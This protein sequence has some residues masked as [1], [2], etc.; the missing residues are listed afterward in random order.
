MALLLL[1][2]LA[3][4]IYWHRTS[5]SDMPSFRKKAVFVIRIIIIILIVL[6]LAGLRIK[7]PKRELSILFVVDSSLSISPEN[8][9]W[10][11]DYIRNRVK[12]LPAGDRAGVIVFGKNAYLEENLGKTPKITRFSTIINS[13]YTNISGAL[14]LAAAV[15]PENTIKRV[16]LISDGNENMETAERQAVITAARGVE[17]R[18]LPYPQKSFDEVL[19]NNLEGPGNIARGEPFSLKM[20]IDS[21]SD[22]KG[23]I[24]V[25]RNGKLI[26][27]EE[28]DI[29]KGK[30]LFDITQSLDEPGNYRYSASIEAGRDR[31]PHNNRAE[32]LTIVSGYPRVLYIYSDSIQ[33]KFIPKVLTGR[34]FRLE[35]G[36]L[37]S[38]PANLSEISQYQGV[39]F[40]NV[41]GLTM[42]VKQM[43]MIENYVK[44]LGG[45]FV[46]IGG[47][48]SFGA[49]G[50]YKSPVEKILPVDLDIRKKKNLPSVAIV[51]CIDKS[52]SMASHT[53]GIEKVRLA[54]EAAIATLE[55]LSPGDKIGVVAFDG[56]AKWVSILQ[57]AQNRDKLIDEIA[58][59]R[60]GGGTSIYPALNS[61]YS[62]LR[63]SRAMIKHVIVLTDG[64]SQPADFKSIA[65]RMSK[66]KITISAV[67]VGKD[68]DMP[69]LEKL[70]KWG[71]G[72]SYYTDEAAMLP[73]IFVRESILAG[74][75]AILEEPFFPRQVGPGEFIKGID[76]KNMPML[77]GYVV[78]V[79][80]KRAQLILQTH[81]K[82]PLL[83]SWRVG[84]GKAVAFTS[85]DGFKWGK[86][87]VGWNGYT[88]FWTQLIRWTLPTARS[89]KFDINMRVKS[90]DGSVVVESLDDEGR[91][92]NFLQLSARIIAPS[93]KTATIPMNQS[94]SGLYRG[95][96]QAGEVGTYFVNIIEEVEGVSQTGKIQAFSVPYS[97]EYRKFDT[98]EYLLEKIASVTGGKLINAGD[99]IFD[100][101]KRVVYYPQPAWIKF[102]IIAL[103]LFPLDVALRRVYLPEN[104][105]KNIYLAFQGKEPIEP[106]PFVTSLDTLKIKKEE[107][108][109][110]LSRKVEDSGL[111]AKVRMKRRER[112]SPRTVDIGGKPVQIE[113]T[114]VYMPPPVETPPE[115][116]QGMEETDQSGT[117]SR[118]KKLKKGKF[119]RK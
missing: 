87:W 100:R 33:E 32:T 5:I 54:R 53:G 8:K 28:V 35:A 67:G 57:Y 61:A 85:D 88:A 110:D 69:F 84:L 12:K 55:V 66:D 48:K 11:L 52:G 31:F 6:S 97:P 78:T 70:A 56:A 50:Y 25:F 114:A 99:D 104:L 96:F 103:M 39:V 82:D 45:G 77:L 49:G 51:L 108:K 79:P 21:A 112:G 98:N 1:L 109:E 116:L 10:A 59:I 93:G 58:S 37:R 75:S 2:L 9:E 115:V 22:C 83:A 62:A 13:Q 119:K 7:L 91:P 113:K 117:L 63:E 15:F 74:R 17:V 26:A 36:N 76:A 86:R 47:D 42:S 29:F 19:L 80:K 27:K 81:Q 14:Q 60:A 34:N 41:S 106:E 30:N 71:Q 111:L 23:N 20:Q 72:R 3:P 94:A 105:F 107:L 89:G 102:L 16:I 40:D 68:A 73:R 64:R 44:D 4:V 95:K 46:M 38:L 90:G 118:L 65:E 101:G 43:K 92:V 18:C 24:K